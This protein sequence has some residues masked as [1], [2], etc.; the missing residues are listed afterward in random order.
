MRRADS[1][2]AAE[3]KIAQIEAQQE[4]K[5]SPVFLGLPALSQLTAR[6]NEATK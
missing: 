5:Q 6:N 1:L 4:R 3:D 2:A